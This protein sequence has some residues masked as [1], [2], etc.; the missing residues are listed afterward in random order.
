MRYLVSCNSNSGGIYEVFN[1]KE[2]A[3][4]FYDKAVKEIN[5]EMKTMSKEELAEFVNDD[6]EKVFLCEIISENN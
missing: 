4:E 6:N 3:T 5:E 1:N 2:K